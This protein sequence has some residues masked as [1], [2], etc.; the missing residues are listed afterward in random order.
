M[1]ARRRLKIDRTGRTNEFVKDGSIRK[2]HVVRVTVIVV[3]FA[4]TR[5]SARNGNP[6]YLDGRILNYSTLSV[7]DCFCY[8]L[9][10]VLCFSGRNTMREEKCFF[11][12]WSKGIYDNTRL[13]K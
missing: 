10:L 1:G 5:S 3:I 4:C 2:V 11:S 13:P 6:R 7:N 8:V 12:Q 9:I